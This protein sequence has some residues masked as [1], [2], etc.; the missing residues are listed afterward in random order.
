MSFSSVSKMQSKNRH[1]RQHEEAG[2][3]GARWAALHHSC[4]APGSAA[5]SASFGSPAHS[6]QSREALYNEGRPEPRDTLGS[7]GESCLGEAGGCREPGL[8]L[9]A[10]QADRQ[11]ARA[12][13]EAGS[14]PAGTFSSLGT[15]PRA[16][17]VGEEGE[18][19][20]TWTVPFQVFSQLHH[21][22]LFLT[23]AP[24]TPR[25]RCVLTA[26]PIVDVSAAD[27]FSRPGGAVRMAA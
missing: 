20:G 5:A 1:S 7:V 21:R 2:R 11:R 13:S 19:A 6:S 27:G 12:T 9:C 24:A 15:R 8:H 23:P 26:W 14:R 18:G 16:L 4:P 22:I 3:E 25:R 17:A 10:G